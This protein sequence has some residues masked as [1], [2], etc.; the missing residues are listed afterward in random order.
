[1]RV[2]C[3]ARSEFADTC[4]RPA[5]DD[6]SSSALREAVAPCR[7]GEE[8]GGREGSGGNRR[9]NRAAA[10]RHG[11]SQHRILGGRSQGRDGSR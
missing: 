5:L 8:R 4:L 9:R 2:R 1:M 7:R 6:L 10:G 11:A 3:I